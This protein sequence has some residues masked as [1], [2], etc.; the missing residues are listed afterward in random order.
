M[1]KKPSVISHTIVR[2][3]MPFIDLVLRQVQPFVNRSL[4]TISEKSK[5]DTLQVLRKLQKEFPNKI[6][7]DFE[8]VQMP[9]LLTKERQKQVSRSYED[10]ILFLDDDDYW[11]EESLKEM[12]EFITLDYDALA[13]NPYQVI[14]RNH[15]DHSWR[16]KWFTKWF[17]NQKGVNYR[18]QW[19]KDLI[20]LNDEILYWRNQN[21][22]T[23]RVKPRYF[24]LSNIKP[25]SFRD[26]KWAKKFK[27]ETGT[28][29]KYPEEVKKHIWKIY[30]ELN[31]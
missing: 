13:N 24:H 1:Q 20:Y 10:W 23:I 14:D 5:D 31:K 30:D 19:P 26:K 16:F 18:K 29:V 28:G 3:G 12:F 2:D 17:K 15:Y 9:G 25:N 11:P 22:R 4:V 8:N 27:S 6:Y 21:K 7:I